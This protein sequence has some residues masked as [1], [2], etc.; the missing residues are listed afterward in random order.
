MTHTE[1]D[2]LGVV[3]RWLTYL[4]LLG[5]LGLVVFGRF[6]VREDALARPVQRLIAAG[7]GVTAAAT[8]AMAVGSGLEAGAPFEYVLGSRNGLLQLARAIV[9]AA[10]AVA[11][12]TLPPRLSGIAAAAAGFI[13]IVLLVS[14]GHAS[15]VPGPIA[16]LAGVVHV[17]AVAIW[18]GGVAGL[19]ILLVR[20]RWLGSSRPPTLRTLVPRFS[21]R[22]LVSIGFVVATGAYAAWVHTGTLLPVGTE[23]GRTLVIKSALA[24]GA[25]GLGGLN[26]LDGGRMRGWLDGFRTRLRVE[27]LVT[28]AVLIMSAALAS[29]PP[30]E[31]VTG[32]EITPVP[33][34]FGEVAPGMSME[35]VPGR[36]G[37]NRIVV[38]TNAAMAGADMELALDDLAGGGSTRVPL[39]LEGLEGMGEMPGMDHGSLI[40]PD[41]DGRVARV[42]DALVLPADSR[43]DASV[44][45]LAEDDI[46]L[47]RQRFSFA[48]SGEGISQGRAES[49]LT[50]GTAIGALLAMGGAVGLGL[51]LGGATLPRCERVASRVALVGGGVVGIALGVLIGASELVG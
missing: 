38:R 43:W 12:V 4:G 20:P 34:A 1:T 30:V 15:A 31:E 41:T 17:A 13:G 6:V 11:V 44:R 3:G 22:A 45:I 5:A 8:L 19:L 27:A 35:V 10:G 40:T 23:Y 29:T 50:W 39:V 16:I 48:I 36:P 37:V 14:A 7:L 47:S 42:A 24:L 51:G 28:G 33:D 18:L 21:A 9:A 49:W 26:F 32:V 46:E 25:I 2:P